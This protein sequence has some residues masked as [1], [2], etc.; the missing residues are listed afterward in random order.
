MINK[1]EILESELQELIL[2]IQENMQLNGKVASGTAHEGLLYEVTGDSNA[3][4]YGVTYMP[5]LQRGT[6]PRRFPR[7]FAQQIKVWAD[8]KGITDGMTQ[9]EVIH[10]I[11]A[12]ANKIFKYGTTQ[13]RTN[14]Y[15]DIYDTPLEDAAY[16]IADRLG[17]QSVSTIL[18][19]FTL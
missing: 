14:L 2:A 10:F 1:R 13:R 6:K 5:T 12:T 15:L 4:L 18:T 19:A 3:T 8:H 16:S 11:H 17:D 7:G 9:K